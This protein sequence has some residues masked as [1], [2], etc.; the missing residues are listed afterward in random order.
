MHIQWTQCRF[1]THVLLCYLSCFTYQYTSSGYS[2]DLLHMYCYVTLVVLHLNTHPVDP[3]QICYT[4]IVMLLELFIPQ[5]TSSGYSSDLLHMYCYVTLVVLHLNTHPVDPVQIC[6]TCTVLCYFS[7]L[8]HNTHPVD[9][10]QI[11]YT[12]IVMLP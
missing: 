8:Y 7:C 1:V 5:Y 10:V 9:I 2:S 11:C 4:C 6:Y 12:C 3:V